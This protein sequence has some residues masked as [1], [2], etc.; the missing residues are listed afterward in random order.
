MV[1]V[2]ASRPAHSRKYSSAIKQ[3]MLRQIATIGSGEKTAFNYLH[4]LRILLTNGS[5]TA[6]E[7]SRHGVLEFIVANIEKY[8]N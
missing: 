1:L 7:V 5:I 6:F 8:L 4:C 3:F 2:Y